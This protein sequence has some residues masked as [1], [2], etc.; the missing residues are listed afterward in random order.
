M[1]LHRLIMLATLLA[2]ARSPRL[3]VS[4]PSQHRIR[5]DRRPQLPCP[6][7]PN[8]HQH[9][10]YETSGPCFDGVPTCLDFAREGVY[11]NSDGVGGAAWLALR[12]GWVPRPVLYQH[13]R[14]EECPVPQQR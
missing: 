4:Q 8:G 10:N 11:R 2:L 7:W 3:A 14:R 6:P 13:Q 1:N 5:S 12:R 9:R